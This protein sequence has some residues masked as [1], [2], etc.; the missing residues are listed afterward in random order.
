[1]IRPSTHT[2][3]LSRLRAHRM[4]LLILFAGV[5]IPLALFGYLAEDVLEH[6]PFFFDQ[7]ILLFMHHLASPAMDTSMLFVTHVGYLYGVIPI[8]I[9]VAIILGRLRLWHDLSFWIVA[10]G[11]AGL[12]NIIAKLIFQRPRPDLWISIAPE[13][14]FSFPS[15]HAMGSMALV[16]ALVVLLWSTRWKWPTLIVGSIFVVLVGISRVYLGVHYPSDI[17]AGWATSLAWVLGVRVI[18]YGKATRA[19]PNA[20]PS[21]MHADMSH[22]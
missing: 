1:M 3:I 11:G 20:E 10:V 12:L 18:L 9:L 15:G 2:T 7:P 6:E 17:L 5:C 22:L 13:A 14:T 16:T 19:L 21:G 8:D 4:Q